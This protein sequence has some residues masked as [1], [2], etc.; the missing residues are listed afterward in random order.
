MHMQHKHL[1]IYKD[2]KQQQLRANKH[3]VK[4]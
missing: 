4:Q 1:H 3:K 2:S